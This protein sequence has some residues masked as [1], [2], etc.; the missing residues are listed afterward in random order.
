[1]AIGLAALQTVLEEGNKD[2]WFG[3]PFIVRLTAIA[4]GSLALFVWIEFTGQISGGQS[5]P[6]VAAQLRLWR[7]VREHA[8]RLRAL[9]VGLLLPHY[10]GQTQGYNSEQIGTV[11]AWTGLPQLLIIPLVPLLM[12]RFDVRSSRS[13][14]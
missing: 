3:S 5:A 13:S 6:V 9:R 7:R 4:R 11:M 2:D 14:A 12:G 1:M 10:L 8:G